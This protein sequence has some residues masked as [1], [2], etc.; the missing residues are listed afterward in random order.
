ML[1]NFCSGQLEG[2]IR[3]FGCTMLVD[4]ETSHLSISLRVL[5]FHLTIQELVLLFDSSKNMENNETN[6]STCLAFRLLPA[7]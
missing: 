6:R 2:G 5:L 7:G 4:L 1:P 3:L